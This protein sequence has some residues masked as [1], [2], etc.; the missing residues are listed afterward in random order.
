MVNSA[1]PGD[2]RD[3]TNLMKFEN[4]TEVGSPYLMIQNG[5]ADDHPSDIMP[6]PSS[7]PPWVNGL[8]DFAEEFKN[9][10][11]VLEHYGKTIHGQIARREAKHETDIWRMVRHAFLPGAEVAGMKSGPTPRTKP[12]NKHKF[13]LFIR[14]WKRYYWNKHGFYIV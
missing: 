7:Q 9:I 6:L 8:N 5:W 2:L 1:G 12:I 10:G 4:S 3:P 14:F 13:H 11:H